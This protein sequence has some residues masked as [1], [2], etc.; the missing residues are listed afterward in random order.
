MYDKSNFL[1]LNKK[2]DW[3]RGRGENLLLA[4]EGISLMKEQKYTF[5][6]TIIHNDTGI[7]EPI[8]SISSGPFGLIFLLD[9]AGNLWTYDFING[10]TTLLLK[11]G[12]NLFSGQAILAAAKNIIFVIEPNP[13]AII[14]VSAV[15]GQILWI[16]SEFYG[17]IPLAAVSVNEQLLVVTSL[18]DLHMPGNEF[19]S[20]ITHLAI[21]K[22]TSE[23]KSH[24][25]ASP[26]SL[27]IK[28][29]TDDLQSGRIGTAVGN[30]GNLYIFDNR[31]GQLW[32]F[33]PN[34]N[35]L[36]NKRLSLSNSAK[37]MG[38]DSEG[39]IYICDQPQ[40]NQDAEN[41]WSV[42]ICSAPN[43]EPIRS[44]NHRGTIE[45][46]W[47]DPENR[48]FIWKLNEFNL[49]ILE[50]QDNI[51]LDDNGN[52]RGVYIFPV[53]DSIAM[54][55]DWHRIT[56]D[57][58]IPDD[59]QIRVSYFASDNKEILLQERMRNIEVYLQDRAVPLTE[60][61][62]AIKLPWKQELVNP[63]DALLREARGRYLWLKMELIGSETRT[64]LL[65]KV[66]I[67]FPR[68][69]LISY[70]PAVY[71]ESDGSQGFLDRFL[72][73]FGTML[74]E[75]EEKIDHLDRIFDPEVVSG[76]FLSWLAGWLGI[77]A[78]D[79]WSEDQ[80]RCLLINAPS[81]YK[82]R[83]TRAG[84]E[85]IIS[86]YTGEKPI[87]VEYFQ[88]KYLQE[89]IE[90]KQLMTQLYGQDPYG[91]AVMV[92]QDLVPSA[93]QVSALQRIIDEEKPAFTDARLVVLQPWIYMD[94]HSYLGINTYLTELSL[95]RLDDKSAMPFSSVIIDME[96]NSQR[97]IH[98]R[99][100]ITP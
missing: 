19:N 95:L 28:H 36:V 87:I 93:S 77:S 20:K 44:F 70:L 96:R 67:Y 85:E 74:Q 2:S 27:F 61:L 3:E 40:V 41:N 90:I 33:T 18:N 34:G 13:A 31:E 63:R 82:K 64:P 21:I 100:Q 47:L 43:W 9:K 26:A 42:Y 45:Y 76:T 62:A 16:E 24:I 7:S 12:H 83:G 99:E 6:R 92:K 86:V 91:F 46:I 1:A 52:P 57:A 23:G 4:E 30:D 79:K 55:M 17:G 84:M 56:M 78:D 15:N 54:E 59:T 75:M 73:L 71:Q 72:S 51:R 80:L 65:K 50:R 69:S 94:M 5:L 49:S 32:I 37:S 14:A 29:D 81:L 25:L 39:F 88:Y 66:R 38:V 97:D 48:I 22:I 58:D 60:K 11:A 35:L 53:L 98:S 8:A 68:T 10:Q 89:T